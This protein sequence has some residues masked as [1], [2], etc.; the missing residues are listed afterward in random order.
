MPKQGSLPPAG[1]WP[2]LLR[3]PPA[4]VQGSRLSYHR[5]A[6]QWRGGL[7]HRKL[8]NNADLSA[9]F[10]KPLDTEYITEEFVSGE[11]TTFDGVCGSQGE[12]LLA[13]SHVSPGSIMEMVNEGNDCFITSASPFHPDVA[14]AGRSVLAALGAKKR[15]F[16]L[17]FRLSQAKES[18]AQKGILWRWRSTCV[19][20][21]VLPLT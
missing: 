10:A 13:A 8:N 16:H 14:A 7:R 5:E 4:F 21:A 18:M 9:F 15:C 6:Q 17:S 19:L 20:P 2:P 12:V 1:N 3:L 11:V